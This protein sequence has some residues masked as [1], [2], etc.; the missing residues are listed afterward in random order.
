MMALVVRQALRLGARRL[1]AVTF[2][3]M[4]RLFRRIGIHAHRAGPPHRIDQRMVVACWIDLDAITL[5]ALGIDET[6]PPIA[7]WP[8]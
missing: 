6:S 3:S 8:G 5:A 1:I 4:E 2:L 7:S